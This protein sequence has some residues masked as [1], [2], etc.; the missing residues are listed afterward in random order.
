MKII[1]LIAVVTISVLMLFSSVTYISCN[2]S[3]PVGDPLCDS[4]KCENGG[5]CKGGE[6]QCPKGSYGAYCQRLWR[7][8]LHGH[9]LMYY[10]TGAMDTYIFGRGPALTTVVFV[11]FLASEFEV[12]WDLESETELRLVENQRFETSYGYKAH[13]KSGAAK[14]DDSGIIKGTFAVHEIWNGGE[15]DS[16]Y[17]LRMEKIY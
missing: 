4:V 15:R 2:K 11:R 13:F 17:S 9:W 16:V 6:C 10:A 8:K 5:T 7:E 3:E 12:M 1:R 14:L